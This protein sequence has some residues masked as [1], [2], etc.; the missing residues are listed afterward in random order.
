MVR[1]GLASVFVSLL[2]FL[3]VTP[4]RAEDVD[5][6]LVLVSDVSRS[7][8]DIEYKLEKDGYTSA[9][10]N[11]KVIE[12]I[13]GGPIGRIAVAYVEF[14]NSSEVRTVLDWTVIKDRASAKAFADHLNAAPR[15]FWGRTAI[16]AGIDKAVQLLAESGLNATRRVIDVGGD[17]TN[18][19]GR[20]A[21]D[22]RD[23]AV[24]AGITINGLAII[25]DHPVSWIFAHVQPPGGLAKYYRE[26]VTGGPGSFVL[27]V[28]D[29]VSFGEAMTRKL[30]D[31]IASNPV[32]SQFAATD[33]PQR[34]SMGLLIN[35]EWQEH[36]LDMTKDGHFERQESAFPAMSGRYYLCVS[37]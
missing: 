14:A 36:E 15:S 37:R 22:A 34:P 32:G 7:I 20:E 16:S 33:R 13:Q 12:A 8:D 26:N 25:N 19:A 23:D 30:V 35:G 2:A 4:V 21:A 28:H 10:T 5:V 29:F 18:N 31:E 17:G 1:I 6:A 9:F 27:E 11:Q 3:P 24:K